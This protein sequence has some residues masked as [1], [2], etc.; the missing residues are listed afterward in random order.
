MKHSS[1]SRVMKMAHIYG[2]QGRNKSEALI[3]AWQMQKLRKAMHNGIVRFRFIKLNGE[4]REALG[5]LHPL[6]IPADAAPKGTRTAAP[7][8]TSIPFFDLEKQEW[9]AFRIT[10]FEEVIEGYVITKAEG[11]KEKEAKRKK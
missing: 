11:K 8:Y 4:V 3:K 7:Q 2:R 5:T 9:R 6:L 10:E 1:S